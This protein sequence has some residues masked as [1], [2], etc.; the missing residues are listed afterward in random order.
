MQYKLTGCDGA[1]GKLRPSTNLHGG[2]QGFDKQ[3]W[4]VIARDASSVT[5]VYVSPDGDQGFPGELTSNLT[6]SLNGHGELSLYYEASTTKPT[7][8]SLTNHAY[9]NLSAGMESTIRDHTLQLNCPAYNP[10]DGSGDGV[11]TGERRA[12]RGTCRDLSSPVLLGRVVDSQAADTPHWPHGEQFVVGVSEGANPNEVAYA[13][14]SCPSKDLPC[15]GT[16][17]HSISGRVMTIFS[18]EPVCQTY[19][20]TLLGGLD[21][22]RCKH[23]AEYGKH[24][25]ICLEMQR[26]ANAVNVDA[27]PSNI[28]Y[29]GQTYR[30]LTV[31]KF[32]VAAP[33]NCKDTSHAKRQ[34]IV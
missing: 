9:F 6:Y 14:K 19:Y 18:S 13:G 32:S 11:P 23:G 17:S 27:F 26:Y 25:A 30:Q 31:Y 2:P 21:S 10:D 33:V 5:L 1:I 12:V 34:K 7:P 8:V 22:S 15:I 4:S 24:G 28:L 29:P 16:L 20:S 3:E